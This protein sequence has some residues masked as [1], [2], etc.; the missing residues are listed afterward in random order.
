M[1][2]RAIFTPDDDVEKKPRVKG[3]RRPKKS[4]KKILLEHLLEDEKAEEG[5][6]GKGKDEAIG[7]G[8]GQRR[9]KESIFYHC[10]CSV[11]WRWKN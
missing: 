8:E 3:P 9:V 5:L 2:S 10:K 6:Q 11:A 1:K 7:A 4:P